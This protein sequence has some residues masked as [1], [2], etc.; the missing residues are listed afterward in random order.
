MFLCIVYYFQISSAT[1]TQAPQDRHMFNI[2]ILPNNPGAP[3]LSPGASLH[4]TVSEK[5]NR[6]PVKYK[7]WVR[8]DWEFAFLKLAKAQMCLLSKG[9]RPYIDIFMIFHQ[10]HNA[11]YY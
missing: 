2:G 9:I 1:T 6:P 3:Q 7:L 5:E 4:M 8:L 11:W 10:W